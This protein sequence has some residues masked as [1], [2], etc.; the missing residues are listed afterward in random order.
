MVKKD[1]LKF[2]PMREDKIEVIPLA[3]DSK[4]RP[5]NKLYCKNILKK[6]RNKLTLYSILRRL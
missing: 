5:L 4:Y 3:A 6:I 2:F 1:I